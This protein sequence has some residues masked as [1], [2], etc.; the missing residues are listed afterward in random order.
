MLSPAVAA[1]HV[2][3]RRKEQ[4]RLRKMDEDEKKKQE[5]EEFEVCTGS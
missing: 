5:L 2:Q 3:I 1:S 4:D